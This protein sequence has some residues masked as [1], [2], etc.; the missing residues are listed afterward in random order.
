VPG[1]ALPGR[2]PIYKNAKYP[3]AVLGTDEYKVTTAYETFARGLSKAAK[4]K[5]LGHRP[6]DAATKTW[7]PYV[8]QTYEQVAKRRDAIGSGIVKLHEN[9][10]L[11]LVNE[12]ILLTSSRFPARHS[13]TVSVSSPRT[14]RSGPLPTLPV[15]RKISSQ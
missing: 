7:G 2:T 5:C 6:Y 8:W 4:D 14:D 11:V 3:D 9:V 13:S 1:S 15:L 12:S 10:R